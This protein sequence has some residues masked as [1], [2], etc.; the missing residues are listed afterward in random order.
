[1]TR[2]ALIELVLSSKHF[3]A[4]STLELKVEYVALTDFLTDA[5][6]DKAGLRLNAR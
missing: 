1:M 4:Y 5:R 3:E 2:Y 6:Q